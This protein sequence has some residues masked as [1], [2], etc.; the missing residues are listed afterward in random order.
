MRIIFCNVAYLRFYDGRIAGELTPVT[1]G[2]WVKSNADAHEKWNFLNMDGKCYG[3]VQGLSDNMHIER[4]EGVSTRD[5]LATDVTV[6]WCASRDDKT[7]IVGWYENASA[8]RTPMTCFATPI[9]GLE[10]C[11]WFETEAEN[12][13]LLP[14]SMRT[15]EIERAS[16]AGK[17]RGFGRYNYW[18]A[19]SEY[20]QEEIVPKVLDYINSNRAYRINTQTS[21][22]L[23]PG[24]TSP[25][26]PE[27]QDYVETLCDD[28]EKEFLPY[29][30]RIYA[31]LKDADAA[32]C[33]AEALSSC[34]QYTLSLPW[35]RKV[36]ELDP[37]DV[38]TKGR[39]GY[40]YQQCGMFE[41]S[42]QIG[43]EALKTPDIDETTRDEL[44]C[45]IADSCFWQHNLTQAVSWLDKLLNESHDKEL[46][47]YTKKTKEA[48]VELL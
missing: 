8:Y 11:Y 7:V 15:F 4:L 24:D 16:I 18:F 40:F 21:E 32:F 46:I 12:A 3:Y 29:G 13:Y 47:E 20:A 41:E 22:F 28:Q 48:W 35:Y 14:E 23:D 38:V 37:E 6:V 39:L 1:G 19:E 26:T 2:S 44:Y 10:R 30:Y 9:S 31:Q 5:Q 17:G 42:I 34:F 36:I 27:E 45:L 33:V 43:E 25:L